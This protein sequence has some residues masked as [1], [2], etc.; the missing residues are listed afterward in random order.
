MHGNSGSVLRVSWKHGRIS[1][2]CK[3]AEISSRPGAGHFAL[4]SHEP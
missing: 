3:R 2:N 4:Q 1:H